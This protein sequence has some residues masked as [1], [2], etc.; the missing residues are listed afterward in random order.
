[1][2]INYALRIVHTGANAREITKI[3]GVPPT[4]TEGSVW[5]YEISEKEADSPIPFIQIFIGLLSSKY[6]QLQALG[7]NRE[8][9]TVWLIYEYEEQCNIEFLPSDLLKLGKESIG[10]C[11]SCYELSGF[12]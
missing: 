12:H 5:E 11:I 6:D 10:L 4:S 3:I 1:M 9:I 7:I 8:N 2:K